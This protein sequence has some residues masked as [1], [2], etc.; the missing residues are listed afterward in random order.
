[1][2]IKPSSGKTFIADKLVK[3]AKLS[4]P[5][6][7]AVTH[8]ARASDESVTLTSSTHA[9]NKAPFNHDRVRELKTALA[10]GRYSIDYQRLAGK[11][12]DAECFG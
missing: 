12:I 11:I 8:T 1:M 9:T 5:S 2:D 10:E 3:V 6:T 7:V 4:S